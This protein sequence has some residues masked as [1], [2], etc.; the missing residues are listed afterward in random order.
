[1]VEGVPKNCLGEAEARDLTVQCRLIC[2]ADCDLDS[3][4]SGPGFLTPPETQAEQDL[5]V[6]TLGP[7]TTGKE[8]TR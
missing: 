3:F 6:L 5:I 7:R 2:S 8:Y 4:D 1:M